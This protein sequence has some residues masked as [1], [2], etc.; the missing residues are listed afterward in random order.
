M[1]TRCHGRDRVVWALWIALGACSCGNSDGVG[2][3]GDDGASVQSSDP[4]PDSSPDPSG[5]PDKTPY[6]PPTDTAYGL[7]SYWGD[8]FAPI[9]DGFE[10][11]KSLGVS[12]SQSEGANMLAKA[13]TWGLVEPE[14]GK[15]DFSSLDWSYVAGP[16]AELHRSRRPV[17][18]GDGE[19]S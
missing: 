7:V 1:R 15:Y 5:D 19:R 18:D 16:M 13:V 3:G 17:R 14:P 10:L 6:L 12:W 8:E 11:M 9:D 4:S 2:T